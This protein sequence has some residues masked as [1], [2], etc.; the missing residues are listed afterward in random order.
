MCGQHI[1]PVD[2]RELCRTLRR[3]LHS[4][5]IQQ[6]QQHKKQQQSAPS[7]DRHSAEM[8]CKRTRLTTNGGDT[9]TTTTAAAPAECSLM[10][11]RYE[12]RSPQRRKNPLKR[13]HMPA[14]PNLKPTATSSSTPSVDQSVSVCSNAREVAKSW[15]SLPDS[16]Y[17]LLYKCLELNPSQ[18]ITAQ[19]AL[20]HPFLAGDI[21]R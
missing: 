10:P 4:H 7:H 9:T 15:E 14:R 3:T 2:L 8:P 12:L 18:R 16:A 20:Q 19:L 1:E 5:L 11:C 6:Q 21:A 17:D 13:S